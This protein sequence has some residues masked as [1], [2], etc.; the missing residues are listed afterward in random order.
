M[1]VQNLN[2][3]SESSLTGAHSSGPVFAL[4][5]RNAL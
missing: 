3:F 1:F 5:S 4:T 2:H